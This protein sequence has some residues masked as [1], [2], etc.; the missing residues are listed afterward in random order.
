M[1]KC[2]E[3]ES[4]LVEEVPLFLWLPQQQC[5]LVKC[6]L[7]QAGPEKRQSIQPDR[8]MHLEDVSSL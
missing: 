7:H 3:E 5:F 8:N 2:C 1:G 4:L 6:M